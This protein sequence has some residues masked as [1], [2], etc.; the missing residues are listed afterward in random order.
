MTLLAEDQGLPSKGIPSTRP[1]V[2]AHTRSFMGIPA[3]CKAK[4][5]ALIAAEKVPEKS[6]K[7][8]ETSLGEHHQHQNLL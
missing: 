2:Q 1:A 4:D 8:K 3:F 7:Q 6:K 5:T